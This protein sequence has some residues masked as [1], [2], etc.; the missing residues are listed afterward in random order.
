MIAVE[1]YRIRPSAAVLRLR[2]EF[3][4]FLICELHNERGLPSFVA[5]RTRNGGGGRPELIERG[6][7]EEL[8]QVLNALG[9]GQ[10]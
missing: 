1:G 4:D 7:A 5:T 2:E 8:R 10:A 6:C 3:P 9:C